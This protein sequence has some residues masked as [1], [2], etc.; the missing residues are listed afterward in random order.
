MLGFA[1]PLMVLGTLL[2]G[3]AFL[4]L[5]PPPF[6]KAAILLCRATKSSAGKSGF[7]GPVCQY[8]TA[9]NPTAAGLCR[10]DCCRNAVHSTSCDVSLTYMGHTPHAAP[11]PRDFS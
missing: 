1:I 5:A 7:P 11:L 3:V 10:L 9:G 4:L 2:S 8:A 6:C